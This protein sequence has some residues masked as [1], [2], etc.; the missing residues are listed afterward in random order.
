MPATIGLMT[1]FLKLMMNLAAQITSIDLNP[2]ALFNPGLRPGQCQDNIE[3]KI[4]AV[5]LGPFLN[6]DR[7]KNETCRPGRIGGLRRIP[8]E[9][10]IRLIQS[11]PH[12]DNH[13]SDFAPLPLFG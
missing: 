13:W 2:L 9:W 10:L 8:D 5:G 3:R 1:V 4:A 7:I 11:E 12:A 6:R